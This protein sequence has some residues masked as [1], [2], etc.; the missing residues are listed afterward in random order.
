MR[1][2]K[3]LAIKTLKK[4]YRILPMKSTTKQKIKNYL[5]SNLHLARRISNYNDAYIL[6][7][8]YFQSGSI[9]LNDISELEKIN[10]KIAVHLHLFYIDLSDEF[11]NKLNNIPYMFDLLISVKNDVNISEIE[12]KFK[13]IKNVNKVI[14]R[15]TKNVGRDFSPMFV[16]FREEILS[17]DYLLHMHSKKSVRTG[18]QQDGWR[19]HME[20]SL[21]GSTSLIKKIFNEFETKRDIGLIYPE[22]YFDMP[23][24]A[25]TWLQNRGNCDEIASRLGVKLEDRYIDYSVGSFFWVKVQAIKK[26]LNFNYTWA[27]FGTEEGKAVI[28]SG[29]KYLV[30]DNKDNLL[31]YKG[32]KN[33]YQYNS[34]D[35]KQCIKEL[36]NYD[37]ISFDIFDTLITRKIINPTDIFDILSK[38]V[39]NKYQ[40]ENFSSYRMEAEYN[41]RLKKNFIGDCSIDEIY[42]ELED[43]LKINN[44][45]IL[46]IKQKECDLEIEFSVPR[47]DMLEIFNKLKDYKKEIILISDMYLTSSTIEKMLNKCGYYGW[48]KLLISSETGLRKDDG[49]IWKYYFDEIVQD[50]TSIHVGDNEQSDVQKLC[51]MGKPFYHVMQPL[52]MF[53]LD[54]YCDYIYANTD[55][56]IT[57]KVALG[58]IVNKEIYN[59][60]F[61]NNNNSY[62]IDNFYNFGYSMLAPVIFKYFTFLQKSISNKNYDKLLFLS[63]EGYYLQKIYKHFCKC[64]KLKEIDNVYFLT[65]RRATSVACIDNIDDAYEIIN[66]DFEGSLNNLFKNRLGIDNKDIPNEFVKANEEKQKIYN[67]LNNNFNEYLKQ[68]KKEA[69]YY[70]KY[71]SNIFDKKS[72]L[73]VIDLG[74][75]GTIQYYLMK[76]NNIKLDGYYFTLSDNVKPTKIGGNCYSC[77]KSNTDTNEKNIFLFSMILE[78]FLTA[79]YGQLV[80]FNEEIKP[81]YK[82]ETLDKNLL[83][84]LDE[85]YDGICQFFTD[86]IDTIGN[87]IDKLELTNEFVSTN[88][89]SLVYVNNI[90]S[91]QIKEMFKLENSYSLDSTINVFD[92]LQIVYGKK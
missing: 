90:I 33:I 75:S 20:D 47:K 62:V 32:V 76:L 92:Y 50:K 74:Y 34:K 24:W 67:V 77:Y 63:R 53:K 91:P 57:D 71:C 43:L 29:Y 23:Y 87:D 45:K 11:I 13:K 86:M 17:Y 35:K 64:L 73:A 16:L 78:T 61:K 49:N 18:N 82:S 59:S 37:I 26:F 9:D 72:K 79:P 46:D 69:T 28:S 44:D 36:L 10:K 89:S 25:H 48:N 30:I 7:Q 1:K 2:I 65:S 41:V 68:F 22:T 81:I 85:I 6:N 88:F 51:D 27:D 15:K 40:I 52:K 42:K 70:K 3:I 8:K 4:I 14:V 38:Y 55:M 31:R 12:T 39:S 19:N 56:S 21:I 58:L 5:V 54:D 80:K 84:K 60:P 66:H 83:K